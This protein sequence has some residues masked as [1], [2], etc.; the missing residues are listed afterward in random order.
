MNEALVSMT[1][2]TSGL[3]SLA[4]FQGEMI[5]HGSEVK[6]QTSAVNLARLKLEALRQEAIADYDSIE[7]GND[8]PSRHAGDS[9]DFNRRWIVTP[10]TNPNY[11][12]VQVTT[13]WTSIDGEPQSVSLRSLI[14]PNLPYSARP[15]PAKGAEPVTTEEDASPDAQPSADTL[16]DTDDPSSQQPET[17]SLAANTPTAT[18]LCARA[19]DGTIGLDARSSDPDCTQACCQAMGESA[20]SAMCGN[21]DCSFVAQCY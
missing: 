11:T 1:V 5:Q 7:S 4:Q 3:L 16:A 12:E 20:S 18:C 8:A 13:T 19:Q 17:S 6:T 15:S 10:H 2:L 21:G 14:A 9:A